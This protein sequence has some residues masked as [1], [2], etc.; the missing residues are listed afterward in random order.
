[1]K[2][3]TMAALGLVVG[4][5]SGCID[6]GL[7]GNIPLEE[8]QDRAPR[9]LVA[10]VY[11]PVEAVPARVIVEGR[12]WVPSGLPLTLDASQLRTIGSAGGVAVH[13][14]SWDTPPFDALYV[15]APQSP[16]PSVTARLNRGEWL[17][18]RPV[19]GR[20]GPVPAAHGAGSGAASGDAH[21]GH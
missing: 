19:L 21:A 10:A 14:R 15:R 6:M 3:I 17:E 16:A 8:A 11:R 4:T 7:D 18:L 5:T 1:M 2:R 13:A 9:A 12:L 20:S